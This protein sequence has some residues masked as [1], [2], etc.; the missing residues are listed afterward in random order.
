[1]PRLFRQT[2][3]NVSALAQNSAHNFAAAFALSHYP[4]DAIYT[5]I[6]KN[7]CS[8]FRYSLALAHGAIE[9][10]EGVHWIHA[11]NI[12][13]RA[14]LRE[15]VLARYAFVLLRD[16]FL[17]LAS[18][19]FDRLVEQS[20][21]AVVRQRLTDYAQSPLDLTFRQFVTGLSGHLRGN[22]HWRPQVDFLV[23]RRYDDVFA[24]EDLGA[25]VRTLGEKIGFEIKD[26][27]PLT[28]HGA[29]RL[30]PAPGASFAD[31]SAFDLLALKRAGQRPPYERFYD[32]AIAG[33]V[34]RLYAD[35]L[36]LYKDWTGR[37]TLFAS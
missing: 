9:G 22:D 23:Y 11:N 21:V 5:Y 16:P 32:R 3:Q 7:A 35:D 31:L 4:S 6:P 27:R 20:V 30:K 25:A 18:C 34:R 1:M 14:S 12:A 2:A 15:L 24:V 28:G 33:A 17:R 8:T 29:D 19:F 26:A 37:Q 10:P 36:A 13:F